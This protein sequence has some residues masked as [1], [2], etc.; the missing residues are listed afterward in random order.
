MS[1]GPD[2]DQPGTVRDPRGNTRLYSDPGANLE[3]G[4]RPWLGFPEGLRKGK[5]VFFC[6]NLCGGDYACEI[7]Q[8]DCAI[9]NASESEPSR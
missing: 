3:G 6:E 7:G 2:L 8:P 5:L 1:A 4:T 9:P